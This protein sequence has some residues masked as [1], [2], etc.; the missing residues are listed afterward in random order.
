VYSM[1]S[2]CPA[3]LE[4]AIVTSMYE[5]LHSSVTLQL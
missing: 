1:Q 4:E 3:L 5:A 2:P